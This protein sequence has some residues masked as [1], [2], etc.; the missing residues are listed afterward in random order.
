[1]STHSPE[2]SHESL[3]DAFTREHHE[4]DAG[5]EAYVNS[6]EPD[7][8]KRVQPLLKAVEALRRH[9]YL[10]EEIVFPYLPQGMLQMPLMVMRRQHG[11][12]WRRMDALEKS[13]QSASSDAQTLSQDCQELLSLL[14][15]HNS[16]EEP[17]IYPHMDQSLTEEDQQK[18]S[19]LLTGGALPEKWVC[20][21]A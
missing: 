3:A 18:V 10:E 1:M 16:K 2:L 4:I 8:L 20:Q 14:D 5:I 21:D 11:E 7:V 6:T 15:N 13:V 17:I 9:I 19:A 12:L